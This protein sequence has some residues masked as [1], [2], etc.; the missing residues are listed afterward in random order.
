MG[1]SR[2]I[3]WILRYRRTEP[4][5]TL[6]A[7]GV[8]ATFVGEF[9]ESGAGW[10]SHSFGKLSRQSGPFDIKVKLLEAVRIVDAQL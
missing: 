10:G 4:R 6:D 1:S 9:D 8:V 7:A 2:W 5:Y 3:C